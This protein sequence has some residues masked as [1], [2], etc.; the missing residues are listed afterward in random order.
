MFDTL[1][2][3][4]AELYLRAKMQATVAARHVL[5]E[6]R[7]AEQAH[8]Q[9]PSISDRQREAI[10]GAFG[11]PW[12]IWAMWRGGSP[13]IAPRHDAQRGMAGGRPART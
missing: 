2:R 1:T 10:D 13:S 4:D 9:Y 12:A 8:S 3:D 7:R 5:T 11:A 6:R